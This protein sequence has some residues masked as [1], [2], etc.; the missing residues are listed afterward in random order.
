MVNHPYDLTLKFLNVINLKLL[1]SHY[2][3]PKLQVVFFI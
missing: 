1:V 2:H 3:D